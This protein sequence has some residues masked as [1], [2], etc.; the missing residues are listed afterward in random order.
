MKR[1]YLV[2]LPALMAVPLPSCHKDPLASGISGLITIP[3]T[4]ITDS[5]ATVGGRFMS[6][7]T[8]FNYKAVEWDTS[9]SFPNKLFLDGGSGQSNYTLSL[10]HLLPATTYYVRAFVGTDSFH[11]HYANIVTLT[12]FYTSGNYTVSTL[13]GTGQ[14]GIQNGDLTRASFNNPAGVALDNT[15]NI[16]IADAVNH[17]IRVISTGGSVSTL[18]VLP[19]HPYDL[20]TDPA[21]N[22]YS[23]NGNDT[24]FKITPDGQVSVMAVLNP[25]NLP[26]STTTINIDPAGNLYV[27]AN[28]SFQRITPAGAVTTLPNP[29]VTSFYQDVAICVDSHFN[30][31]ETDGYQLVKVDSSGKET[32]LNMGSGLPYLFEMRPD[33][34]GNIYVACAGSCKI[35]KITAGGVASTVAG[36]GAEGD[37]DGNSGMA[38]FNFPNGLALDNAGNIIVA[39]WTNNK[40]RK[41]VPR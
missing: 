8:P 1:A 26:P 5:S 32:L 14:P 38:T 39:D 33:G 29:S 30:R 3:A 41:I 34:A 4:D 6:F 9:S 25:A 35:L 10:N 19:S 22:V 15:G 18:A 17:A 12:T 37:R 40:I 28:N 11:N 24:V 31:Y 27:A 16:F 21:G 23:V 2:L 7:A 20:V 36:T 13:A